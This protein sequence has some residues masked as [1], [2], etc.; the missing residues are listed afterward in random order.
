M[1]FFNTVI[2]GFGLLEICDQEFYYLKN[3]HVFRN[4]ASSSKNEVLVFL[5]CR[6]YISCTVVSA[7]VYTRCH[8]VQ[9]PVDSLV[10]AL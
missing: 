4:G 2:P 8:G 6:C 10:T 5:V 7:G 3:M 1:V 9:I